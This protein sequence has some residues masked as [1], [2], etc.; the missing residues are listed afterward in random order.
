MSLCT[1]T[2]LTPPALCGPAVCPGQWD[3]LSA[4]KFVCQSVK[5]S[6]GEMSLMY[7]EATEELAELRFQ[8]T[9]LLSD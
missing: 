2:E 1:G 5:D 9:D 7:F 8:A 4:G 3:M 6:A